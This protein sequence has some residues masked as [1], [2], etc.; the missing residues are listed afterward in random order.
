MMF[1]AKALRQAVPNALT[2]GNG[3]CGVSGLVLASSGKAEIAAVLVFAGWLFDMV[4]GIAARKLGVSGP[5]GAALDSLCDAITFGALPGL[6][7]YVRD[8]DAI[9]VICGL[10]F[11]CFA[12]LRLARYMAHTADTPG[13]RWYFEGLPS[14]AAAMMVALAILLSLPAWQIAFIALTAALAMVSRL[15]YADVPHFFLAR[16]WPW[17]VLLAPVAGALALGLERVTGI[18]LG[19]YLISG[20]IVAL[21]RRQRERA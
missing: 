14:P 13:P 2:L 18:I 1:D 6:L 20:P 4:D 17:L 11:A 16:H 12:L 9:A 7:L 3:L 8:R 15:P 5:F 19:L 21:L 10:I